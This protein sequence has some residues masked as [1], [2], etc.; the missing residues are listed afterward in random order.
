MNQARDLLGRMSEDE[1]EKMILELGYYA[2]K[3]RNE[4]RW[5]TKDKEA[6]PKGET[7][8]SVVSLALEKVWSGERRWNPEQQPNFMKFM[9]DV[10]DSLINHLARGKDNVLLTPAPDEESGDY[11]DRHTGSKKAAQDT[12]WLAR[13]EATPEQVLIDKE[14]QAQKDEAIRALLE[15]CAGDRVLTKI[16]NAMLE[17]YDQCGEIAEVVGIEVKDVYNAMKRLD[18]KI[19]SVS[20]RMAN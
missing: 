3:V 5:R 8:N 19:A 20:R 7:V 13:C 16:V 2:L 6:L 9:R 17:G 11:Q 4:Y 18:R 10:I 15:E 14:S 1:L 12:E